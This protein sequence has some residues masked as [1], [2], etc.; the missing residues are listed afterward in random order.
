MRA[1]VYL[2]ANGGE[3]LR[4]VAERAV[5]NANYLLER[6]TEGENGYEL[7]YQNRPV[8]HEF[9]L[10]AKRQKAKGARALDLAKGLIDKGYHPADGLLPA[11]RGRGD[12][13]RADRDREHRDA[14]RVRRHDA[15]AGRPGR[16]GPVPAA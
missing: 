2:L 14:R 10:S 1:F 5:L 11:D 6:L 16:A 13:G 4:Q 7:G 15:G 3:G 9:V 8:M 12:D